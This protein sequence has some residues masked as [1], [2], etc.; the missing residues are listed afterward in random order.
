MSGGSAR[1]IAT[2]ARIKDHEERAAAE[3]LTLARERLDQERRNLTTVQQYLSEYAH[4][5]GSTGSGPRLLA[6]GQRFRL[7]LEQ[8]IDS[9]RAAVDQAERQAET[10]R[11]HWAA[12]RSEREAMNKLIDRRRDADARRKRSGEQKLSDEQALQQAVRQPGGSPA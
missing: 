11:S 2:L 9:Q 4:R 10:A 12:I 6:D 8:T 5:P 1:G 7:K 3:R